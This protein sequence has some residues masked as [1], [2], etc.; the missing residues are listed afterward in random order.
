MPRLHVKLHFVHFSSRLDGDAPGVEGDALADQHHWR[1]CLAATVVMNDDEAQRL[2][3]A[4]C[5]GHES[6][7]AQLGDL[8]GPQHLYFDV[9]MLA[10]FLSGVANIGGGMVR[11]AV[12]PFLA[13]SM[14]LTSALPSDSNCCE[15]SDSGRAS[16]TLCSW[17]ALGFD[18]VAVYR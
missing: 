18:R 4:L 17:R 5:H 1:L 11:G 7:H 15:R 8:F 3:R 14:P 6:A 9:C 13:N 10:Q 12:G 2:G 16:T